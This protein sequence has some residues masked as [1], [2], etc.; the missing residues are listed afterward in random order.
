M[1]NQGRPIFHPFQFTQNLTIRVTVSRKINFMQRI[2]LL[3]GSEVLR[4]VLTS[5]NPVI[6]PLINYETSFDVFIFI[7]L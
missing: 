4:E 2:A 5:P 6:L 7:L 3:F 1:D